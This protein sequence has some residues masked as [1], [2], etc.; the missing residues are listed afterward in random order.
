VFDLIV[1]VVSIGIV[2][3]IN[4]STIGPAAYLATARDAQRG[5]VGFALGV[6][7]ASLA[8]GLA[9][10]L[11]PGQLLI[12]AIPH[13]SRETKHLIE[14]GLGV[15]ALVL[16]IV[17]WR[18]RETVAST[19]RKGRLPRGRSS[20]ALGAG[21]IAV[22]LPTAFPYFAVIAA[23]VGSDVGV[24]TQIALLVLFNALFVAPVLVIVVMRRLA[25]ARAD[26]WLV[27]VR[28]WID[29]RAGEL[30]AAV[31][32]AAAIALIAVGGIGVA[33]G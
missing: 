14:L 8:A 23:I 29:E 18:R 7:A 2:D 24:L 3:S 4:P 5:L 10:T 22:E 9:L 31:L 6:F 32:L 27:A 12:S 25:S 33:N 19:V 21:I 20:F 16:G 30:L 17:L 26:R 15:A 1:L 13:V 11:G 28:H